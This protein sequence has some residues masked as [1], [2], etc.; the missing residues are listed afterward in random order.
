MNQPQIYP[1]TRR[2]LRL[3]ATCGVALLAACGAG[4]PAASTG[5]AT[6]VVHGPF[7]IQLLP[8]RI[9]TGTFPNQGGNPFATRE[10]T[11]FRVRYR[12]REVAAP[13]GNTRFWRVLRLEG[14]PRPALL[15]VTQG[16]VLVEE[17]DGAL[18]VQALRANSNTLAETQWL[19][20]AA[21]QPGEPAT[22]GI[23]HL[24]DPEAAT[25]LAG[26]RWLRLG[27]QLILD[28]ATL[29]PHAVEPWVPMQPGKPVTEVI[30]DG[31][32]VRAFSPGRTRYVLAGSQVDYARGQGQV[33]GLL[34]VDIA[35]GTAH[36]IRID[37][38]QQR[39]ADLSDIDAAWVEHHFAWQRDAQGVEQLRPR[40]G[41]R[42]WPRRSRVTRDEPGDWQME[43]RGIDGAFSAV[44]RRLAETLPPDCR[45]EVG[46]HSVSAW[47]THRGRQGGG[48]PPACAEALRGF[49][50]AVD[51]ELA[52]GRH[53]ALLRQED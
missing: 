33:Y 11:D 25:R 51:A 34:V 12:G 48:T 49:V 17:V 38:R 9:S 23:Q 35:A 45:P 26:G 19:D 18:R 1:R 3:L 30:R 53:D 5:A 52:S 32:T 24:T 37:P 21:G 50:H 41:A 29:T 13:S 20:S 6:T 47:L 15:L 4:T 40:P 28:V 2:V 36:E 43:V 14:T 16:F 7:E 44:M 22:Y 27:A 8:R 39:F 42:P 10:V 31:D 46:S